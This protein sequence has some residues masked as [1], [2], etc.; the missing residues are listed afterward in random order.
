MT[1]EII[2]LIEKLRKL[3][4]GA[5]QTADFIIITKQFIAKLETGE[6]WAREEN[7]DKED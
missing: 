1:P 2:Y 7:E 5:E 6:D 3:L 4:E